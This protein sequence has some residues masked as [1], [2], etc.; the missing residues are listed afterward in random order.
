MRARKETLARRK[1]TDSCANS[2]GTRVLAEESKEPRSYY[3]MSGKP[4]E[5]LEKTLRAH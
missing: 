5:R 1:R 2:T 3:S 4:V